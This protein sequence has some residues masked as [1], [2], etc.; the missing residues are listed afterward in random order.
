V[1]AAIE[2]LGFRPNR[3][4]RALAGGPAESVTV[5][6]GNT[7]LYGHSAALRGV[8]EAARSAGYT[9]GIRVIESAARDGWSPTT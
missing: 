8:E 4:A 5:L 1:R 9:V 2:E 6:T 7:T 3:A